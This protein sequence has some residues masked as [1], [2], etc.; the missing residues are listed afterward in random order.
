[1]SDSVAEPNEEQKLGPKGEPV[2][3]SEP[4]VP[5]EVPVLDSEAVAEVGGIVLVK[6]TRV[7]DFVA[8]GVALIVVGFGFIALI[9]VIFIWLIS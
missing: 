4:E 9:G 3:E 6:E 1:M 8:Y 2:A 7:L 5:K